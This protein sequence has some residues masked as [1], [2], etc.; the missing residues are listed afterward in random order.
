MPKTIPISKKIMAGIKNQ[1]LF[2]TPSMKNCIAKKSKNVAPA[3]KIAHT[4]TY[5]KYSS[6]NRC[7]HSTKSQQK[8][9]RYS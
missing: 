4:H 8:R 5:P 2:S 9:M 1:I 3:P 6:G 7:P